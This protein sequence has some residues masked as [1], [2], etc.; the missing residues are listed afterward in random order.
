VNNC[1]CKENEDG[2]IV[3]FCRECAM[4]LEQGSED[5]KRARLGRF[6]S[7][8]ASDAFAR[9]K[10]GWGASRS[11]YRAELICERLSGI[12]YDGY[13][14]WYM[15]RGNQVEP[16]AVVA[17]ELMTGNEAQPCGFFHHPS[18]PMAGASPDRLVGTDGLVEA[19][20][21]TT[22]I[23]FELLLTHSIPGKFIDQIQ[24]SL[25]CTGRLWCDFVSYDP[26]APAGMDLFVKRI[27]R[28]II[29]IAELERM[30][31]EFLAE[32]DSHVRALQERAEGGF[33]F[34]SAP[35]ELAKQ[36]EESIALAKKSD[37][38]H[39]RKGKIQLVK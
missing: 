34:T 38:V 11:N 23:H 30:G 29:R 32:V 6:T 22:A 24:F 33:I 14:N 31:I 8:R 36:L 39:A 25:A 18:I 35:E 19:K 12:P 10:A 9:T 20:A 13:N 5:W 2:L 37:V 21:R 26:R 15:Q 16:E 7:S 27:Y 3:E 28:D 1:G 4:N 17:Y